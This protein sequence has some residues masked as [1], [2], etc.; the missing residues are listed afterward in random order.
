MR[1]K[2]NLKLP[3]YYISEKVGKLLNSSIFKKIMN[4]DLILAGAGLVI[5]LF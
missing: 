4:Y 1:L 3:N 5:H 2:K